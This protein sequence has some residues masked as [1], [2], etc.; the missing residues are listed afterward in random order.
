M[1]S[2]GIKLWTLIQE[3]EDFAGTWIAHCLTLDIYSH[4]A[5]PKE[6]CDNLVE[7]AVETINDDVAHG[8]NP[9]DRCAP[10]DHWIP[11]TEMLIKGEKISALPGEGDAS[12]P[13]QPGHV[14]C[15]AVRIDL[16]A[17]PE[18]QRS[19]EAS[20]DWSPVF[21]VESSTATPICAQA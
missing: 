20:V 12:L 15:Y 16:A 18:E 11:W 19:P 17:R 8:F 4:G 13:V 21:S 14:R 1:K 7:S 6:A 3:S 5:T 2:Q 10:R 9:I